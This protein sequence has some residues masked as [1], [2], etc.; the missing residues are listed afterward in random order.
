V[1]RAHTSTR[2]SAGKPL[3]PGKSEQQKE[4]AQQWH[5]LHHAAQSGEIGR[6]DAVVEKTDDQ[7]SVTVIRF[8]SSD[9]S[10]VHTLRLSPKIT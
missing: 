4:S 9:D 1:L 10:L 3:V 6:A 5:G 8:F 2:N 7:E